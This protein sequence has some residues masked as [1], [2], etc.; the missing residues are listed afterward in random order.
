MQVTLNL[1]NSRLELLGRRP[2]LGID[3]VGESGLK[4]H[5]HDFAENIPLAVSV[6]VEATLRIDEAAPDQR[7]ERFWLQRLSIGQIIGIDRFQ[8][9][10]VN[11]WHAAAQRPKQG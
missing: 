11:T 9:R 6:I 10:R 5:L 3:G 7:C 4:E 2:L 8:R 1:L